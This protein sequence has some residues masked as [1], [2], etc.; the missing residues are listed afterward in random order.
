M[1]KRFV[2]CLLCI[3]TLSLLSGCGT[4]KAS[5]IAPN[6]NQDFVKAHT[7][8]PL[9]SDLTITK[10]NWGTAIDQFD[11]NYIYGKKQFTTDI[12]NSIA[13]GGW[14]FVVENH[15]RLYF[16]KENFQIIVIISESDPVKGVLTIEP[17]GTEEI[18]EPEKED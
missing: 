2:I 7:D 1:K 6:Y 12:K 13:A 9:P 17:L 4:K 14:T 15:D 5:E 8:I 16:T 11:F 18:P 10:T 3:F